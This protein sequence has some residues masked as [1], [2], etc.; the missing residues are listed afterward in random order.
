MNDEDIETLLLFYSFYVNGVWIDYGAR[1]KVW[2]YIKTS[3]NGYVNG[4]IRE[5]VQ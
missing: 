5:S 4:L 3:D 1:D 2:A